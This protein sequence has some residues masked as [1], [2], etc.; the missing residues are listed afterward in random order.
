MKTLEVLELKGKDCY[1]F[2]NSSQIEIFLN[3][4]KLSTYMLSKG[5]V[6]NKE[7]KLQYLSPKTIAYYKRGTEEVSVEWFNNKNTYYDSGY[8]EEDVLIAIANRKEKEGFEPVYSEQKLLDFNLNVV[9]QIEDTGSDF[10]QN[11]INLNGYYSKGSLYTLEINRVTIDEYRKLKEKYEAHATFEKL[12]RSYL[13]FAKINGKYA[14]NDNYPFT[15]I[16]TEKLFTSLEDAVKEETK[17]RDAVRLAVRKAV[18]GSGLTKTK[19]ESLISYL[20]NVTKA[21]TKETADEMLNI[22][23]EDLKDFKNNIKI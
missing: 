17:V 15:Q 9:G 6:F 1:F 20:R 18:F 3:K 8:S 22:I 21:K 7:D 2:R 10:I 14:F 12:D 13:R 5:F 19:R 4:E 11:A 23:I 16:S